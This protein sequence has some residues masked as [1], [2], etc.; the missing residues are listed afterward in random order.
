MELNDYVS[1]IEAM[2]IMHKDPTHIARLC[3]QGKLEGAVKVGRDWRIPRTAAENYVPG[4]RGFA[5][6]KKHPRIPP[7]WEGIL[8]PHPPKKNGF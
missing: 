3:R 5:T 8:S 2:D 1:I 4:P 6:R 7:E